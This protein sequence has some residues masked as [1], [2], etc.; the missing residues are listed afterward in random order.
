MILFL[1]LSKWIH[2]QQVERGKSSLFLG[3]NISQDEITSLRKKVDTDAE[4]FHEIYKTIEADEEAKANISTAITLHKKAREMVDQR[5]KASEVTKTFSAL[6]DEV[7]KFQAHLA[8][9]DHFEGIE[10]Y[11][12]SAVQLEFSRKF[13]G[14]FRANLTNDLI[15]NKAV[16]PQRLS[17]LESLKAGILLGITTPSLVLSEKSKKDIANF[18]SFPDWLH[19][20]DVYSVVVDKSA[21]G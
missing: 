5:E 2:D 4:E 11:L 17:Y 6:I 10:I 3:N 12:S 15:L 20:L 14:R 13:A 18:N 16:S 21:T 8:T 19:V 1:T 9:R 7:L